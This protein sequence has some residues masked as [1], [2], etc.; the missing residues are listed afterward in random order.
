MSHESKLAKVYI[1]LLTLRNIENLFFCSRS[2]KNG[3]TMAASLATLVGPFSGKR[4]FFFFKRENA[5]QIVMIMSKAWFHQQQPISAWM[6]FFFGFKVQ[7]V[8]GITCFFK[9]MDMWTFPGTI[10]VSK[11]LEPHSKVSLNRIYSLQKALFTNVCLNKA[12][13]RTFVVTTAFHHC[14]SCCPCTLCAT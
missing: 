13:K 14:T 6:Y 11:S 12:V 9:I 4:F 1:Y 3:C 8:N 7:L 2:Q 5:R 10:Y